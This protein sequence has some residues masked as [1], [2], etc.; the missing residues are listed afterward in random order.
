MEHIITL[1]T[2]YKYLILFPLAIVEGPIIAIIAGFLCTNGFMNPLLVFPIIVLGDMIGD[3]LLYSLGRWGMPTFFRKIGHRLGLTPERVDRARV[4]FDANP[5]KTIS[6]SKITLGIGVAGIYIAGNAKIPYPKFIRIC[7]VT[8]MIQY[9]VYLGIGL[10]FGHAY[11]LINHY[12]NYIASF[13]IVT[14]LVILL[15]FYLKSMLKKL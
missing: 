7:G 3:S 5:E 1:L 15:F 2:H 13:F 12:L 9:F 6:L 11:L 4:Y 10:T 14:A 8:S